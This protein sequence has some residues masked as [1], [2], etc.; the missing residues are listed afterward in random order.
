MT[1]SDKGDR[2]ARARELNEEASK[3]AR[4]GDLASALALFEES[5]RLKGE[6]KDIEGIAATL[7]MRAQALAAADKDIYGTRA[8]AEVRQAEALLTRVGAWFDV[9]RAAMIHIHIAASLGSYKETR[10]AAATGA[11]A[12]MHNED[13]ETCGEM[14]RWVVE[15]SMK[16]DEPLNDHLVDIAIIAARFGGVDQI[17]YIQPVIVLAMEALGLDPSEAPARAVGLMK[18]LEDDR[19]RAWL[20]PLLESYAHA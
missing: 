17:E 1:T 19:L 20:D 10:R 5:L 12:A 16:M 9:A 7:A 6:I 18:D 2:Q 13:E 14:L 4:T 11:V 15:A 8:I 3:V